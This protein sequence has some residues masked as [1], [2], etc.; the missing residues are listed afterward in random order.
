MGETSVQLPF[1][2][3]RDYLHGTTLYRHLL[4][5]IPAQATVCFRIS[6]IIQTN[7]ILVVPQKGNNPH[8]EPVAAK[9]NWQH[10]QSS[11]VILVFPHPPSPPVMREDYHEELVDRITLVNGKTATIAEPSPFD[12]VGS[13][14][15]MFKALL[16]AQSLT[17]NGGQ[18]MFSRLDS[19]M[20]ERKFQKMQLVLEDARKGLIAKS[21]ISLDGEAFGEF[22]FSWASAK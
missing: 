16:K 13:A 8:R 17:P 18:W 14:V 4:G 1:L 21:S 5:L 15:P 22:Y 10:G 9:L 6:R 12:V 19:S 11:G 20:A 2:G 3:K 7:R